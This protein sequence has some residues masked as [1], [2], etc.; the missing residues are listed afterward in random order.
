MSQVGYQRVC[1]WIRESWAERVLAEVVCRNGEDAPYTHDVHEELIDA[2]IAE[3]ADTGVPA[4]DIR[5]A[6]YDYEADVVP[7]A[8]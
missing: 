1:D 4:D 8:L 6:I 2:V 3:F 5:N 7:P